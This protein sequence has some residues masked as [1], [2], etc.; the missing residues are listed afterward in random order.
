MAA[1]G[2]VTIVEAENVVDHIPAE[3]VMCP[4]IY[5]HRVFQAAPQQIQ[6]A[7]HN[8]LKPCHMDREV[9]VKRAVKE[10]GPGM[11]INLGIG[12]P[13][14]MAEHI[15]QRLRVHVQSENGVLG[16]K[17][18]GE[19]EQGHRDLIDAGKSQVTISDDGS[20]FSSSTSFGMI[21]GGKLHT[22]F[23]G[24][25][26]VSEE[27]DL[28]NWY[29]EGKK[30][31]GMGGAMDLVSGT[32]VVVLMSHSTREQEH[33]VVAQCSYPLTGKRCVDTLVT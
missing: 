12:M 18:L 14:E 17:K 8:G 5:V 28:A 15:P 32:R 19:S 29:V 10:I 7:S 23:L 3:E 33:K 6:V 26:Q 31:N 20:Y 1:A 16:V 21:R 25:L 30:V 27:G 2:R 9:I 24:G 4:G 11:Y 22:T 13:T